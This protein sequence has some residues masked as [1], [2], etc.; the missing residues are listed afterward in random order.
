MATPAITPAVSNAVMAFV[1]GVC[2]TRRS[3][4]NSWHVARGRIDENS[5]DCCDE[6]DK[7]S[8]C[9]NSANSLDDGDCKRCLCSAADCAAPRARQAGRAASRAGA[10]STIASLAAGGRAAEHH[11]HLRR[12]DRAV[13]KSGRSAGGEDLRHGAGDPGARQEHGCATATRENGV[14]HIRDADGGPAA[15]AA[16]LPA[17]A[18]RDGGAI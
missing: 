6:K 14:A 10:I 9:S 5:Q 4:K 2:G 16:A 18:K 1:A 7:T 17:K 15:T 12:L 13:P 11:R 3:L 8:V